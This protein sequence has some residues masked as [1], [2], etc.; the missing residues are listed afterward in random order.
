MRFFDGLCG[1]SRATRVLQR[2]SG[3]LTWP[4]VLADGDGMVVVVTGTLLSQTQLSSGECITT[5]K[6]YSQFAWLHEEAALYLKQTGPVGSRSLA[7][8]N[9]LDCVLGY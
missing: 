9:H 3:V 1:C 7:R 4:I 8:P 2:Y 6:R 5:L